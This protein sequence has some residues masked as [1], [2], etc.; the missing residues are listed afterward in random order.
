MDIEYHADCTYDNLEIFDG[1]GG[2]KTKLGTFCGQKKPPST[3]VS[4]FNHLT[5][6]FSSDQ[7]TSGRGFQANYSFVDVSCGGMIFNASSIITAPSFTDKDGSYKPSPDCR[8]L[9]CAPLDHVIQM[10]FVNFDLDQSRDCKHDFVT[11]F[12]N[13]SSSGEALGPFCG[14]KAPKIIT[15]T[16]NIATVLFHSDS[17]ASNDA[18]SI[19][20]AFIDTRKLCGG[21]FYSTRGSIRSPGRP[22][23]LGD[24]NCE[25]IINAP[26]G[27]QI[28]L[29][30]DYF[31]LEGGGLITKECRYDW[32][33]IRNGGDRLVK[34]STF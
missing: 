23:Y 13:D 3:F 6:V 16:H 7:S 11:I 25:W 2:F 22:K 18:F 32:L 10:T 17:T 4:S 29:T 14:R 9:V 30:F 1:A 31:E 33:E 34:L 20:L 21:Q 8:W 12:N 26:P 27:Q 19:S 28:E 5:V 24:Q 15:T